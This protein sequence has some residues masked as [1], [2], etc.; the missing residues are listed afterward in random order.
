MMFFLILHSMKYESNAQIGSDL[1]DQRQKFFHS[2]HLFF[3]HQF[4]LLELLKI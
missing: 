3:M 2:I 1:D 4:L